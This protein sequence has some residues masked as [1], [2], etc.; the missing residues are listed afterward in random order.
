MQRTEKY[1]GI[2]LA[3]F[4]CF[5]TVNEMNELKTYFF[6]LFQHNNRIGSYPVTGFEIIYTELSIHLKNQSNG[7]IGSFMTHL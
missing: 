3:P 7:G 5:V 4:Y 1:C 2:K 6:D